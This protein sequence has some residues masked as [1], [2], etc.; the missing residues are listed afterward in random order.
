MI[1]AA[2]LLALACAP[3]P[4]APAAPVD[5]VSEATA[6][7]TID[8][9][10]QATPSPDEIVEGVLTGPI[11]HYDDALI[12]GGE[13]HGH[14]GMLA[15]RELGVHVII[16]ILDEP[17]DLQPAADV[18]IAR[19]Q[20]PFAKTALDAATLDR[21]MELMVAAEAG[22]SRVYL[23]CHGGKHRAGAL[24]MAWRLRAQGWSVEDAQA[25][26]LANGGDMATDAAMI[27]VI[28]KWASQP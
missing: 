10:T 8:A 6:A 3:K 24:A 16:S 18:G 12:R 27:A 7:Y 20:I 23:H 15:L 4:I 1:L 11:V 14:P 13:P 28:E 25:E 17:E 2:A 22:G 9:T 26:F 5:A 21:F 19:Y